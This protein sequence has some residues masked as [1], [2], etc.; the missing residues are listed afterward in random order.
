M[1]TE[2]KRLASEGK[3]VYVIARH[4]EQLQRQIDAE[5][6]HSGIKC[7]PDVPLGFDW[8]K[9]RVRGS[10]PN[11]VWLFDHYQIES[12]GVFAA[13]FEAMTRFDA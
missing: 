12:D 7:E 9:M 4:H 5:M 11:C 3:A 1:L 10:H 6:P 8:R 2:A 13:M